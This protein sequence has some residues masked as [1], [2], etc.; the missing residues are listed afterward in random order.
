MVAVHGA[1]GSDSAP[2]QDAATTHK[3]V[4]VDAAGVTFADSSVLSVL[5]NFHHGHHLCLAR[6]ACRL[7]RVL[8]LTGADRVLDVRASVDDAVTP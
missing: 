5:L 3:R 2:L 8:E 1:F 6:P 7:L 4:V